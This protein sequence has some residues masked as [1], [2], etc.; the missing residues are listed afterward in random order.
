MMS[1]PCPMLA[2]R[3]N[4][5]DRA[6]T[7]TTRRDSRRTAVRAQPRPLGL[8]RDSAAR[9]DQPE[10][11][12]HA[13][14][15]APARQGRQGTELVVRFERD[16]DDLDD[17]QSSLALIKV[18]GPSRPAP[19]H[20]RR[21][22]R[23]Q[24]LLLHLEPPGAQLPPRHAS[25]GHHRLRR[26]RHRHRR[27]AQASGPQGR[28]RPLRI[29]KHIEAEIAALYKELDHTGR[30]PTS[31]RR[32]RLLRR[33]PRHRPAEGRPHQRHRP[34]RH[35]DRAGH[36]R[37]RRA[38]RFQRRL[39]RPPAPDLRRLPGSPRLRGCDSHRTFLRVIN[40]PHQPAES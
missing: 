38:H 37:P 23:P 13:D 14:G 18:L 7:W 12:R 6:T 3:T 32:H 26:F 2:P 17:A 33:S 35:H 16:V 25:A 10:P 30:R 36:R 1:P 27:P 19:P 8:L 29:G 31:N 21:T 40:D 34:A 24:R 22:P 15:A 5:L 11:L 39:P 20:R 4:A 9:T 28:Q